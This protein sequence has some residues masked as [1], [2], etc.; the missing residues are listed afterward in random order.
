MSD[1]LGLTP[2]RYTETLIMSVN[3]AQGSSNWR[4]RDANATLPIAEA[5][6][7]RQ[8]K[9]P[10]SGWEDRKHRSR[11]ED[12]RAL[13]G[14]VAPGVAE[15]ARVYVGNMP[16]NAQKEDVKQLLEHHAIEM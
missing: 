10:L 4:T 16:Y 9:S 8:A 5:T 15:G 1:S 13:Q 2:L 12:R 7:T 14:E 11:F 6:Y 3:R